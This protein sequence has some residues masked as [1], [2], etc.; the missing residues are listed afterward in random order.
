MQVFDGSPPPALVIKPPG[1]ELK[2]QFCSSINDTRAA[3]TGLVQGLSGVLCAPVSTAFQLAALAVPAVGWFGEQAVAGQQVYAALPQHSLC[4]ES[5]A[6][7]L[8]QTPCRGAAGLAALLDAGQLATTP[9]ASLGL[10]LRASGSSGEQQP[11]D[12]CEPLLQLKQ[13]ATLVRSVDGSRTGLQQLGWPV[14][15][16]P[17]ARS[18]RAL[19]QMQTGSEA[20]SRVG[21]SLGPLQDCNT[22]QR[23]WQ[24]GRLDM[25]PGS[26]AQP[27][28]L[29]VAR[30]VVHQG[31][32]AGELF[33]SARVEPQHSLPGREREA[34]QERS[35]LHVLQLVPRQLPVVEGSLRLVVDGRPTPQDSS[36]VA[37]VSLPLH[38]QRE[39][40]SR[41]AAL[42]LLLQLPPGQPHEVAVSLSFK[43]GFLGVFDQPPDASRGVDIPAAVVTLVPPACGA[44]SSLPASVASQQAQQAVEWSLLRRLMQA[45]NCSLEQRYSSSAVVQLLI[46]DASMPFNVICLTSTLLAVYFGTT[47]NTL[48]K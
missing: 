23:A 33:L 32:R 5:L 3:Y 10:E 45:T 20:C 37:W 38:H 43:K 30:H 41:P 46:P 9:F 6:A 40:Y 36:L 19:L 47:V 24:Q 15:P 7:W 22:A 14:A 12:S 39:P 29:Q 8:R 42:E 31:S 2:V 1:L 4:K 26:W 44:A 35:L 16:C 18:S 21:T 17:A 11:A 48:L 25:Q 28:R 27:A 13:T 34:E